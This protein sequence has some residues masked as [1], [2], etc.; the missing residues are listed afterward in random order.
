MANKIE[1]YDG[2]PVF[3]A[4]NS[5]QLSDAVSQYKGEVEAPYVVKIPSRTKY[6]KF[7]AFSDNHDI[8]VVILPDSVYSID[9]EAFTNCDNLSRIILSESLELI[10]YDAFIGCSSLS[11]IKIPSSVRKIRD[12]AF[13]NCE[14]LFKITIPASVCEIG[15]EAFSACEKL[16]EVT[17]LGLVKEIGED[18]F[19]E[20][21]NLSKII[22]PGNAMEAYRQVLPKKLHN[23]IVEQAQSAT[24][25]TNQ[26]KKTFRLEHTT[27]ITSC[28]FVE[29]G[30]KEEAEALF[31]EGKAEMEW[32][33][34]DDELEITEC[35]ES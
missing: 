32:Q 31:R 35:D 10:D 4:S 1:M 28:Y 17:F 25:D 12:A 8:G 16:T 24:F 30:S 20:C 14:S 9:E 29:A 18:C 15:A 26:A 19:M 6:I 22:V 3:R 5:E 33:D 2:K 27:T 7:R 11:D 13:C 34:K 21:P 23:L